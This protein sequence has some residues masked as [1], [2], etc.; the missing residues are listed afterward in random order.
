MATGRFI[1]FVFITGVVLFSCSLGI[2]PERA[3]NTHI[4]Q[5][6][7]SAAEADLH[8]AFRKDTLN[9]E[10]KF[11]YA[12]YFLSNGNPA[13][14]PDSA[15]VYTQRALAGLAQS[16][17]K[18]RERLYKIPIDSTIGSTHDQIASGCEPNRSFMNGTYV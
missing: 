6:K 3:A 15:H 18:Q 8:K 1:V 14:N 5:K 2:S 13:F 4:G 9:V 12:Q 17:P 10:A 7:W 11:I 16:T